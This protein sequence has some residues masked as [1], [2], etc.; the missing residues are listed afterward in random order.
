MHIF[1]HHTRIL[2]IS[3]FILKQEDE[4]RRRVEELA[5]ERQRRIAERTAAAAAKKPVNPKAVASPLKAKA[6]AK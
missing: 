5:A 2:N 1:S 3:Y 4:A 6:T